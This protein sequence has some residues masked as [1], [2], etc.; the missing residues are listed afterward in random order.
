ML[1]NP[2]RHPELLRVV[3]GTR[4]LDQEPAQRLNF[5]LSLPVKDPDDSSRVWTIAGIYGPAP[6]R[7]LGG[8][9]VKLTDQK[10]FTTFCNQRDLELLLGMVKPG[11]WCEW[12][13][14][15]YPELGS[16]DF[17]G[18]CMDDADLEDDLLDWEFAVRMQAANEGWLLPGNVLPDHLPNGNFIQFT[19]RVHLDADRDQEELFLFNRDCDPATGLGPDFSLNHI[20]FRWS[21]VEKERVTWSR[22]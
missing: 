10:G 15:P 6:R 22:L 3:A 5:L 2:A 1:F 21:R 18:L 4:I 9:R 14:A 16:I 13:S 8:L 12:T 20:N 19:R 11:Q 17:F 7:R